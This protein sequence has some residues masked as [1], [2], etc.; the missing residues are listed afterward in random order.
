MLCLLLALLAAPPEDMA[1][2]VSR[3]V[4]LRVPRN[5]QSPSPARSRL[6]SRQRSAP[7]RLRAPAVRALSGRGPVARR[8]AR[9]RAG[10]SQGLGPV[11]ILGQAAGGV[12]LRHRHPPSAPQFSRSQAGPSVGAPPAAPLAGAARPV[13][14]PR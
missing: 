10:T 11:P 8:R 13:L 2:R 7:G 4:A 3:P 5:G 12:G 6:R 9:R 1:A 14:A